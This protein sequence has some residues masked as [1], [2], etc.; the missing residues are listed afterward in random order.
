V[1]VVSSQETAERGAT[2]ALGGGFAR[3]VAWPAREEC[4]GQPVGEH[5]AHSEGHLPGFDAAEL[6]SPTGC[7][8]LVRGTGLPCL[9]LAGIKVER[10]TG[11]GAHIAGTFGEHRHEV[12]IEDRCEGLSA[13]APGGWGRAKLVY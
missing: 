3:A 9:A 2:S 11:P 5:G 1:T 12:S 4:G 6:S 8:P 10:V 7:G 13:A